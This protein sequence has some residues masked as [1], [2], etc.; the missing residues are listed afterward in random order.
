MQEALLLAKEAAAAGEVPVGAVVVKDNAIIGRGY[1]KRETK[2]DAM[3]H[4]ETEAIS[5]ACR[6]TGKWRLSGCDLYVTLEPCPMCAGAILGSRIENVYYGSPDPAL[7]AFGGKFDLREQLG[8]KTACVCGGLLE[9][10]C[11][12]L[13]SDFFAERRK[14]QPASRRPSRDF[15]LK[16]A[17]EFAL[18]LLGCTI[19]R[20]NKETGELLSGVITETECYLGTGDTACHASMGMTDRNRVMWSRGGTVYVYLCYGMHNM[21]NIV[22]GNKGEPEAV[23]IRGVKFEDKTDGNGPGKLTKKLGID[24]KMN[25]SDMLFSDELWIELP[26]ESFCPDYEAL[27][28]VGID[29][30]SPEDRERLWRYRLK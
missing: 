26:D 30:A 9:Q 14:E 1:N 28:R 7:G 8:Q 5:D 15:F 22:S 23:L 29:Y 27:P 13:L 11:G 10:E 24:R 4:A 2:K 21:L 6:N 17:D 3:S 16:H 12:G 18:M 25:G 20:K 19:K